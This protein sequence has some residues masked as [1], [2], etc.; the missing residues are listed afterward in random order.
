M[1]LL[2]LMFREGM[3]SHSTEDVL[4][5]T[6]IFSGDQN[7]IIFQ[8]VYCKQF[9]ESALTLKKHQCQGGL[10]HAE[11]LVIVRPLYNCNN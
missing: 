8:Q 10:F 7:R 6:D 11:G 4:E 5:E 3:F 1:G 2:L 9:K